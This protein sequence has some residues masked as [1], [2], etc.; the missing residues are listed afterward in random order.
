MNNKL[1]NV[2]E[3][4]IQM[5]ESLIR[6]L[7]AVKNAKLTIENALRMQYKAAGCPFGESEEGLILWREKLA[8]DFALSQKK[9]VLTEFPGN[10]PG[11]NH[12]NS[13]DVSEHFSSLEEEVQKRIN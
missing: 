9:A 13:R 10:V 11:V 4:M 8:S 7:H 6:L 12:K 5:S 2:V 3:A 1:I